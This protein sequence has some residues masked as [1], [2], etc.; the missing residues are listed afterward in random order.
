MKNKIDLKTERMSG[1]GPYIR[2]NFQ[3][4]YL[5]GLN[6]LCEEFIKED[7]EILE[8]GSNDGVST[9]LF[10][11]FASKVTAVDLKETEKMRKLLNEST[12]INFFNMSFENFLSVDGDYKYDLIYIDG[13]HGFDSVYNDIKHFKNKVKP[14]GYIAGH[15]YIK[16]TSGVELAVKKHFPNHEIK[17]FSDSSWLIKI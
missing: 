1:L 2:E 13:N 3:V 15:D 10:S 9:S 7:F 17:L 11:Y 6:E 8:L 14:Y 4:N 5:Y 16:E 12:N